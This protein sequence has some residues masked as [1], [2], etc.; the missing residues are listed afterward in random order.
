MKRNREESNMS[1]VIKNMGS[2]P[3]KK[4]KT[5]LREDNLENMQNIHSPIS[6]IQPHLQIS[7]IQIIPSN[8]NSHKNFV[9]NSKTPLVSTTNASKGILKTTEKIMSVLNNLMGTGS[10]PN[11]K[12]TSSKIKIENS[13][14]KSFYIENRL[15]SMSHVKQINS[16]YRNSIIP[17]LPGA[18]NK[19]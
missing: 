9:N 18:F 16:K 7:Q 15:N 13:S 12:P 14:E 6:H 1:E 8:Q 19:N 10:N 11:T 2:Q 4:R 3:F 17:V 5:E